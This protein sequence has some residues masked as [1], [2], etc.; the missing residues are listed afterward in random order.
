MIN[1]IA[2]TA[3]HIA[4]SQSFEL[5]FHKTVGDAKNNFS[6]YRREVDSNDCSTSL[7]YVTRWE[8]LADALEYEGIGCPFDYPDKQIESGPRGGIKVS[9]A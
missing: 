1:W 6:T 9:N 2:Y 3:Q 5:S 4:G 7:Y 8:Q